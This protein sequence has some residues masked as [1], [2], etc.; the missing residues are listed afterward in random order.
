MDFA[1]SRIE[2]CNFV[3]HDFSPQITSSAVV[4]LL[5]KPHP[6]VALS[7]K[8]WARVKLCTQS[9][10]WS[11]K[12]VYSP[13]WISFIWLSFLRLAPTPPFPNLFHLVY[14]HISLLFFFSLFS[15]PSF[16]IL[17]LILL[18]VTTKEAVSPSC[19]SSTRPQLRCPISCCKAP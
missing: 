11:Q 19:A 4:S 8:R 14:F 18:Q 1:S 5:S 16:C 15:Y 17:F 13:E 9:S 2:W 7:Q 12:F 6:A 10:W 3:H